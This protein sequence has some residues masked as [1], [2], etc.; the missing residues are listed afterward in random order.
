MLKFSAKDSLK[1]A[2]SPTRAPADKNAI[3]QTYKFH[4]ALTLSIVFEHL[5]AVGN[6]LAKLYEFRNHSLVISTQL[7]EN[8]FKLTLYL[9]AH[10]KLQ[11]TKKGH[12]C[13]SP[14]FLN[15]LYNA[16]AERF[17]RIALAAVCGRLHA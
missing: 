12:F 2:S 8:Y 14:Y 1:S 9:L 5:G 17:V 10:V 11:E 4:N 3:Y 7:L 15:A 16:F 6:D 13:L